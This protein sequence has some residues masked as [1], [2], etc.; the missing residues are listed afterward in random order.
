MGCARGVLSH[1]ALIPSDCEEGE[2]ECPPTWLRRLP[3]VLLGFTIPASLIH[4]GENWCGSP[5]FPTQPHELN[6]DSH[7][8]DMDDGGQEEQAKQKK[9]RQEL[10]GVQDFIRRNIEVKTFA[11]VSL[12]FLK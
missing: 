10:K 6:S 12:P 5:V 4:L 3:L 11:S 1:D 9:K 2:N 8:L 7:E